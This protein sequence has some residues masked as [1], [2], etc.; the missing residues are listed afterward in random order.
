[1]HDPSHLMGITYM[2][3]EKHSVLLSILAPLDIPSQSHGTAD[4]YQAKYV[5]E[6]QPRLVVVLRNVS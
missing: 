1:M 4:K 3:N 6:P 5:R 2:S